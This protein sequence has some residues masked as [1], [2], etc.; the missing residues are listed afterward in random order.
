MHISTF[1]LSVVAPIFFQS[2]TRIFCELP[3][4]LMVCAEWGDRRESKDAS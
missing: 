2:V 1:T 3:A 4:G